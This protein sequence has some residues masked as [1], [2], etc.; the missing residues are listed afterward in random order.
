MLMKFSY[1]KKNSY[2]GI[3]FI[4]EMTFKIKKTS[5]PNR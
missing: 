2:L 3:H 4:F 5:L 1:M